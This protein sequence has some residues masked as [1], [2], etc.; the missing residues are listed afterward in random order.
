MKT[1]DP[2]HIQ[3]V[4]G[5]LNSRGLTFKSPHYDIVR[6][7][8]DCVLADYCIEI[9]FSQSGIDAEGGD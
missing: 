7:L 3:Q 8:Q 9:A 6:A 4:E 5:K 2:K 1:Y